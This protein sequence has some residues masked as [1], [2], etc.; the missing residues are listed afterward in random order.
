VDI[1]ASLQDK[2]AEVETTLDAGDAKTGVNVLNAYLNQLRAQTGK[3]VDVRAAGALGADA[4][5]LQDL[6]Q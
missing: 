6:L 2:L 1:V 4:H 5:W 3:G